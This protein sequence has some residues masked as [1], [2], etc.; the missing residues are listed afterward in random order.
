MIA[1]EIEIGKDL[2]RQEGKP[3]AMLDKIAQGRLEKFYKESTLLNQM[4]VKDGSM[5][6]AAYMKSLHKDLTATAFRHV[7]LG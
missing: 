7:T 4:Y 5:T 3:E 6:V 1:K 2:A